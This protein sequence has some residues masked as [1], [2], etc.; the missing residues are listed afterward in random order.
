MKVPEPSDSQV[1]LKGIPVFMTTILLILTSG[2]DVGNTAV[3]LPDSSITNEGRY[4][5]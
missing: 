3:A 5:T 4:N 2:F 1:F